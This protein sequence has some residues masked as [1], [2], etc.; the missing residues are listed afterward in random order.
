M[1]V[2][3]VTAGL[4]RFTQDF[5][6][7]LNQL[8]GFDRADLYINLWESDWADNNQTA[9][10]KI[11]KILPSHIFLKKL[12]ITKEPDRNL[13]VDQNLFN[14]EELKWWYDR[15]IGQIHCL[16][17]AVDLIDDPYDVV[18]RIRPDGCLYEDLDVSLLDLSNKEVIFCSTGMGIHQTEPNDQF[19][20]GTYNGIKFLCELY[21]NFDNYIFEGFPQWTKDVHSWA[22]EYMIGFHFKINGKEIFKGNFDHAIMRAGRSKYTTDKH[23]HVHI[24]KDPTE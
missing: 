4:P 6:T 3:I 13:P 21:Q 10:N 19:F 11:N 9:I 15:R 20:I 14:K 24:V 2:A 16:K 23:Q 7:V 17:L 5:I 1:K 12:N 22:L 8:K 18:I